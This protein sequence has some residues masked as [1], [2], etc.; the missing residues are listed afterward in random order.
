MD[1]IDGESKMPEPLTQKEN[2]KKEKKMK[3]IKQPYKIGKNYLIR[4]VTMIYTGKLIKVFENELVLN[5]CCWIAETE[6]WMESVKECKFKEVEPYPLDREVIIGRG[7][8]L[9][10]VQI[11]KLPTEQK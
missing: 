8:I 2:N 9:D 1:G 11:D 7:A 4:T 6:R 10:A 3:E 5:T